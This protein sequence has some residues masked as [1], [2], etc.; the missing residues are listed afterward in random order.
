MSMTLLASSFAAMALT[1]QAAGATIYSNDFSQNAD[2]FAIVGIGKLN[3]TNSI[4]YDSVNKRMSIEGWGMNTGAM[5]KEEI[6]AANFVMEADIETSERT[7][8]AGTGTKAVSY[9]H[10]DVYK[11][12]VC[13]YG[14]EARTEKRHMRA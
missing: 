14:T 11:R 6:T 3:A 7:G 8:K 9:T 5:L 13:G 12:Q 4:T 10:L 1:A 2:D